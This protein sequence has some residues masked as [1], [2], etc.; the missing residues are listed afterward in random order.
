MPNKVVLIE[1]NQN[2]VR[3]L[4]STIHW[5]KLGCI[6]AGTAGD[7]ETGKQLVLQERPDIVLTDIH[8]PNK[9]GLE[10]LEELRDELP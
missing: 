4:L 5:D 8:M 7:G 3:S 6:V 10:M 9:D 2:T 1:D